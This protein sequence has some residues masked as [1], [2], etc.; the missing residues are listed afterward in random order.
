MGNYGILNQCNHDLCAGSAGSGS[1]N[2][3]GVTNITSSTNGTASTVIHFHGFTMDA[4][5]VSYFLSSLDLFGSLLFFITLLW[6]RW[7]FRSL[8][9]EAD[10]RNLTPKDYTVF[11]RGVPPN[12]SEE[13][14][15]VHFNQL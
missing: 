4:L 2:G 12:C 7:H 9:E 1:R 14:L 3:S 11:V 6:M 15:L 8:S 10:E 13:M 5:S